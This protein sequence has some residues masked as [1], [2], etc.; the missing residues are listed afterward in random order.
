MTELIEPMS[1]VSPVRQVEAQSRRAPARPPT[2]TEL[3]HAHH[4]WW[5]AQPAGYVTSRSL[6][7]DFWVIEQVE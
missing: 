1:D 2:F 7:Q 5:R 3:V 6:A 4:G